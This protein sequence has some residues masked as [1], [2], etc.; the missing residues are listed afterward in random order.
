MARANEPFFWALFSSGGM[1]AALTLPALAVALWL[2]G[3]LGLF[4]T[5]SHDG[6]AALLAHPAVRASLWLLVTLFVFHWAHRFRFTLYDGLQ[7]Y[8][9]GPLIATICYGGAIAL[10]GAAAWALAAG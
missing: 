7:L 10:S 1:L 2:G 6:L 9:L 4:A 5:P 8:H 3:P